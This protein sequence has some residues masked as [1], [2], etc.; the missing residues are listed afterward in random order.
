MPRGKRKDPWKAARDA[1][2]K[3]TAARKEGEAA[4]KRFADSMDME[5]HEALPFAIQ[6]CENSPDISEYIKSSKRAKQ[7]G[8]KLGLE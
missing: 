4:L 1:R 7:L 5:V 2:A 8:D 3:K 6:V